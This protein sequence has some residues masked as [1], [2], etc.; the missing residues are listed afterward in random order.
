MTESKNTYTYAARSLDDPDVVLTFTLLDHRLRVKPGAVVEKI[1]KV[2]SSEEKPIELKEQIMEQVKPAAL[3][4]VQGFSNDI[5]LSDVNVDLHGESLSIFAW[6]RLSGLR[7][8][9]FRLK[10]NRV[11]NVDAAEA[12]VNELNDR[13]ASTSYAGRFIGPLDYWFSWI[14]LFTAVFL[15]FRWPFKKD[16]GEEKEDID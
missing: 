12:F 13:K 3:S 14:A 2:L 11:D 5:H 6:N 8:A 15:L 4:M 1:E 16:E 7:L 9:P 10:I